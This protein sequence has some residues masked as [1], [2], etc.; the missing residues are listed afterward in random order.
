MTQVLLESE[1]KGVND[2][3]P[4]RPER[5]M[6]ANNMFAST[7]YTCGELGHRSSNHLYH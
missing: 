2:N 6:V 1:L 4:E 7:S 3:C 5:A